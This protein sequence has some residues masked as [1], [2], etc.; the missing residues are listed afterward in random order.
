M[1]SAVNR[2]EDPS[3]NKTHF[4]GISIVACLNAPGLDSAVSLVREVV[5]TREDFKNLA[6]ALAVNP[7][8]S[9]SLSEGHSSKKDQR[10][11][12]SLNS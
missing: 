2:P 7:G 10:G 9:V 1:Q 5:T 6:L 3:L 4:S 8:C 11:T 12:A